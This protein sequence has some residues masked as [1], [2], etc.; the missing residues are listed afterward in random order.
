MPIGSNAFAEKSY[1][2]EICCGSAD[3]AIRAF[4]AGADRVE[5]NM[6]LPFGGLT[7]SLG[8]LEAVKARANGPVI[9]MVRPRTGGF[10]Y[11]ELEFDGM[12]RD[13]RAFRAAGADGIAFGVLQQ[14]GSLDLERC[15]RV[16]EAADGMETAFHRAFDSIGGDLTLAAQRLADIGVTR[17]LTSGGKPSAPEGSEAIR[18]IVTAAGDRIG[19]LAGGGVRPHNA[20][21]LMRDTGC[22]EIHCSFHTV[23]YDRSTLG[24]VVRFRPAALPPEEEVGIID[25]DGLSAFVRQLREQLA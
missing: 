17:I 6:A 19:V 7:P 20:A 10:C 4:S 13:I 16:V 9:C 24:G 18:R 14:D 22:R 2:L 11:S 5:L 25:T 12:L 21:Q 8:M 15:R 23:S 3:D 1:L